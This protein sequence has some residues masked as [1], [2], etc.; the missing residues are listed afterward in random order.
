[1]VP[2]PSADGGLRRRSARAGRRRAPRVLRR[3]APR[4]GEL[5]DRRPARAQGPPGAGLPDA[6]RDRGLRLP[7]P[8]SGGARRPRSRPGSRLDSG[9]SARLS[10]DAEAP[11]RSWF[12]VIGGGKWCPV[13]ALCEGAGE[14]RAT[15]ANRGG[16]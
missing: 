3:L 14:T 16:G 13:V 12:A 4:L 11:T 10:A 6:A 8:L 15:A 7:G 9:Q 1:G 2:R 5:P